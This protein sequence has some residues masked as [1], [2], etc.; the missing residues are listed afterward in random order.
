MITPRFSCSQTEDAVIVAMYC[1]SIRAADVEINVDDTLVTVHVNPYFLRLNFSKPVLEDDNSSAKYDPS[2]GTLTITLTKENKGEVF[3]DL[4]L[5]AK[6]LAPRRTVQNPTPSIE[7][8]SSEC[9]PE[10]EL[11]SRTEG[12]SLENDEIAQAAEN[13]WQLPQEVPQEGL[14]PL[15]LSMQMHY[16]FLDMHSGYLKHATH[17]ENEINELGDDAEVCAKEEQLIAWTHPHVSDDGVF[18]YTEK[19][20]AEMLRLP[21]KEYLAT[22]IQTHDLYLTLLT[23]LFSY[24]YDSRTSQHDPTPESAWTMGNLTPAFTALDPPHSSRYMGG[25]HVFTKDELQESLVP[26]YRRSLTFPLYRSFILVEKCREDVA[27]ILQ[28]GKRTVMRCLLEMKNIF[29]HHEVYYIYSKIWI[30]DFCVWIQADAD[31]GILQLLGKNLMEVKVDKA[32]I[33]WDLDVIEM[34]AKQAL[35]RESDSDDETTETDSE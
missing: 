16:G 21:R 28:K 18:Q 25:H 35:E 14:P 29:D 22:E 3:D 24:M 26:S 27:G 4:D 33:G 32:L 17:T 15:N 7:V 10:D 12:L 20:N 8:L 13:D 31:D 19:E 11:V 1:P 9:L 23:L 34:A 2:S 5:L 6:L 30:D